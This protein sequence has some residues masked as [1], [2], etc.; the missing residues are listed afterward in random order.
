MYDD[1]GRYV[2]LP[3]PDAIAEDYFAGLRGEDVIA[4]IDRLQREAWEEQM[5]YEMMR[6]D[7]RW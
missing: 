7:G 5:Y 2:V 1:D 6:E 4:E 3:N